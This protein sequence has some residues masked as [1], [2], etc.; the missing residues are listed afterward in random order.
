M[1]KRRIQADIWVDDNGRVYK[2]A[3]KLLDYKTKEALRE[4]VELL[5][6]M[7]EK[8]RCDYHPDSL[9]IISLYYEKETGITEISVT[10]CCFIFSE[11]LQSYLDKEFPAPVNVNFLKPN[12]QRNLN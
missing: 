3:W 7:M 10:V 5:S 11:A 6:I 8:L 12:D 2:E 9:A 4:T 1:K